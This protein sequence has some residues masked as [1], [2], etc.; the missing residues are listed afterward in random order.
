[1]RFEPDRSGIAA[2]AKSM[3]LLEEP[4]REVTEEIVDNAKGFSPVDE[5][6]YRDGIEAE[7]GED[8]GTVTGRANATDWKSG[9]IEFGTGAPAPTQAYAPL[10]RGA[11]KAGLKV[12]AR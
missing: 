9:F 4:I 3:T 1:M 5:G 7:V 11:E 6:D 2:I 8:D 12:V 10:R